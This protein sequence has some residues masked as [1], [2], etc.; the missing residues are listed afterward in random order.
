[1][2]DIKSELRRFVMDNFMVSDQDFDNDTALVEN[3]IIDSFGFLEM[4]TFIG[5]RFG[6]HMRDSDL[7]KGNMDSINHLTHYIEKKRF[8]A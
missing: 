3:G 2:N 6:V 7:Q 8:H 4:M 5:D 1:M